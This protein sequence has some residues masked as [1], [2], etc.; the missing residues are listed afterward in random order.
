MRQY[1]TTTPVAF[2]GDRRYGADE[3]EPGWCLPFSCGFQAVFACVKINAHSVFFGS[4]QAIKATEDN[5]A[6]GLLSMESSYVENAC[7]KSH[8]IARVQET[9]YAMLHRNRVLMERRQR[10]IQM[11]N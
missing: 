2:T 9:S 5:S 11:A 4:I 8:S 6:S 3:L 7:P 1:Q 10:H